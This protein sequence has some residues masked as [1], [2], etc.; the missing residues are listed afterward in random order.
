MTSKSN[1]TLS[2]PSSDKVTNWGVFLCNFLKAYN[3]PLNCTGSMFFIGKDVVELRC[4]DIF[5]PPPPPPPS[6]RCSAEMLEWINEAWFASIQGFFF[7]W[8]FSFFFKRRQVCSCLKHT[9]ARTQV[10]TNTRVHMIII[11]S[12]LRVGGGDGLH[13]YC[14]NLPPF[15]HSSD[16][17]STVFL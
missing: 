13:P 11:N 9:H 1:L 15:S 2:F 17:Q 12:P 7:F 3:R 5:P 14:T 8:L 16:R 6:H 4:V 10:H